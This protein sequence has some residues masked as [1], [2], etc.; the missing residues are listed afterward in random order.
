MLGR[1]GLDSSGSGQESVA[2]CCEHGNEPLGSIKSGNL[3][4]S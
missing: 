3:L 1:C 2:V 4:N